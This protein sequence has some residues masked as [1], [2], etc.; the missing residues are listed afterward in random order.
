MNESTKHNKLIVEEV[1]AT[2]LFLWMF[3]IIFIAYDVFYYI[4]IPTIDDRDIGIF[5]LGLG[6]WLYLIIFG[7]LPIGIY[8]LKRR[9]CIVKYIFFIGYNL[10]DFINSL[11]IYIGTD[12]EFKSGNIV[13]LVFVLGSSIFINKKYFWIVSL[14]IIIKYAFLGIV[15]QDANVVVGIVILGILAAISYLFLARFYSYI[16]TLDHINKELRQKEKMAAVG[17]LATSIGHEIRN[18]LAALRGFTQLQI[19]KYPDDQDVYK[20][21]KNEI[22]R[23][24][25]IVNDLLY[26]GKPKTALFKQEDIKSII[27]YVVEIHEPI[28][29]ENNI[30][31][32]LSIHENTFLPCDGN[33]LK[34]VFINLLKNAMESMPEGG[35]VKIS[36]LVLETEKLLVVLIED[37]GYGI[38]EEKI[39]MLGKPFYSTKQDGNGLGLMVSHNIIEQHKGK[40]TFNS[41]IGKGTTVE[42]S[43]PIEL[44]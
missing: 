7:L 40:I 41:K 10:I 13:E 16:T 35:T 1:K 27:E 21:M 3:Y 9:P 43:L 20:I 25:L 18:P 5:N 42:I 36:S 2:K 11:L 34:Q 19:E 37:E 8:H 30:T 38:E 6:Y 33:Q 26:I 32:D 14:G 29:K 44:K 4:I 24:N 15:L 28:A 22:D 12:A 17:Q 39:S 23:I 31:I